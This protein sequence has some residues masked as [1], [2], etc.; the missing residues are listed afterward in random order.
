M[1][2]K[3]IRQWLEQLEEPYKTQALT[4]V[5]N[6]GR[7][8][9]DDTAG[10]LSGAINLSMD[11]SSTPQGHDYWQTIHDYLDRDVNGS[12][13]IPD[14][15]KEKAEAYRIAFEERALH[16]LQK[17]VY[18]SDSMREMLHKIA[19][20]SRVAMFMLDTDNITNDF[21]NYITTRGAMLSYLPNGRE[22]KVNTETGRWLRDGRQEMKP[23]KLARKLFIQKYLD[24]LTDHDFE[25]FGNKV[26][27]YLGI[28]GDEDGEGRNI[29]LEVISGEKI[30]GAYHHSAYS[31]GLGD[32]TNLHG[33]CMRSTDAQDYFGIYEKNEDVVQMLVAKDT[34]DKILGRALLWTFDNGDKGMDTIYGANIIEQVFKEWAIDNGYYYKSSQ[35]CHHHTFDRFKGGS[36]ST[37]EY[38]EKEHRKVILKEWDFDYYPYVDSLYLLGR[39]ANI[40]YLCN[41]HRSGLDLFRTLRCTDGGYDE[42]DEDD[43]DYVTLENG[44]SCHQDDAYH[45]DYTAHNGDRV[46]GYYHESEVVYTNCGTHML[47]DHCTRLGSG[48]SGEWYA[49]DDDDI[50]YVE[51]RDAYYLCEYTVQ[52]EVR[53]LTIHEDD[54][55]CLADGNFC[56]KDEAFQCTY[57]GEWYIKS[58]CVIAPDGM[59]VWEDNLE[60]YLEQ[61]QNETNETERETTIA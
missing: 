23:A 57:D 40:Y 9:M 42:Q 35:S 4:N 56:D 34:D 45:L 50:T 12:P 14:L 55:V 6:Q 43:D 26:R 24:N 49:L 21:C 16:R 25:V 60:S 51:D 28:V 3:P 52:C 36:L 27:A 44:D 11:W 39:D 19:S 18:M 46:C 33:S 15:I 20:D 48:R 10:S 1:S 5:T 53:E 13:L 47:I 17:K 38:K 41:G 7:S 2:R 58:E 8:N 61:I 31:Y 22:H 29:K 54:A 30:R 37:D 32:G 59:E